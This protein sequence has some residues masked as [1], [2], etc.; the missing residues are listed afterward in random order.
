VALFALIHRKKH[1]HWC[2]P[3]E[4]VRGAVAL[5]S[6]FGAATIL[7]A[8]GFTRPPAV[9][10]LSVDSL[11]I[12]AVLVPIIVFGVSCRDIHAIFLKP[13][14]NEPPKPPAQH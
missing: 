6:I 13:K 8:F 10:E 12:I 7:V 14:N 2:S 5:L 3:E 9:D 4:A 1:G 11:G